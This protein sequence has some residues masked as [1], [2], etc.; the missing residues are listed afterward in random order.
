MNVEYI[1]KHNKVVIGILAL[2]AVFWSFIFI[3]FT[4]L[5]LQC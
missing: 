5:L 3:Q 1:E 4:V 2:A